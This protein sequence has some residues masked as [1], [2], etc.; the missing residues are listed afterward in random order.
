MESFNEFQVNIQVF[1]KVFYFEKLFE[2]PSCSFKIAKLLEAL[3]IFFEGKIKIQVT[4]LRKHHLGP[5][6]RQ[7]A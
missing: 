4:S 1:E 5:I 7:I 2:Q 6:I 3:L